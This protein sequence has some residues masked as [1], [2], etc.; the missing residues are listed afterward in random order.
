MSQQWHTQAAGPPSKG[1]R[2]PLIAASVIAA[3]AIVT[4]VGFGG[5]WVGTQAD[6]P[7]PVAATG[8]E[9]PTASTDAV[10]A[11]PS[12]STRAYDEGTLNACAAVS[13]MLDDEPIPADDDMAAMIRLARLSGEPTLRR[14]A[15][16]SDA[17]DRIDAH[18]IYLKAAGWCDRH[19][20]NFPPDKED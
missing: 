4:A 6:E 17:Y 13:A 16:K 1:P 2:G 12:P 11:F 18:L 9:V 20:V 10:S 8:Q 3:V 5:W 15:G 7:A 14:L 19:N